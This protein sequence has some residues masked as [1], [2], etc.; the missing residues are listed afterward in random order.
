MGMLRFVTVEMHW[1]KT[2][3]DLGPA[4][5]RD[6]GDIIV[7][8]SRIISMEA[9]AMAAGEEPEYSGFYNEVT[10]LRIQER[11]LLWVR[12]TLSEVAERVAVARSAP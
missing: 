11:V 6:S 2:G 1:P 7:D 9:P 8:A 3:N 4:T 5:W 12:G 10:L